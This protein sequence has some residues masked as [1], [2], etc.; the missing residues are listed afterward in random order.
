MKKET[1]YYIITA[2]FLVFALFTGKVIIDHGNG[3]KH[4]MNSVARTLNFEKR[5]LQPQEWVF[6]ETTWK[7]LSAK[8]E[9]IADRAEEEFYYIKQWVFTFIG[10]SIIYLG[11]VLSLYARHRLFFR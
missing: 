5:L 9:R 3:Y 7:L 11:L 10:G 8:Y 4:E 1:V 6:P 2:L